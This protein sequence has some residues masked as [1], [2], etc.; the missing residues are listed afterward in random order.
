[1]VSPIN[2]KTLGVVLFAIPFLV[3]MSLRV[4]AGASELDFNRDIRPIL[5]EKCFACHGFNEKSRQADLRLDV[6]ES[7]YANHGDNRPIVL[8]SLKFLYQ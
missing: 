7:A 8:T 2:R 1:M 5:S 4:S 3:L 6:A